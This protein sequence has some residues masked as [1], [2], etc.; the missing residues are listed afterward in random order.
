[1]RFGREDSGSGMNQLDVTA[2]RRGQTLEV[3]KIDSHDL[4]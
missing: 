1:V 4:G 3:V 2:R